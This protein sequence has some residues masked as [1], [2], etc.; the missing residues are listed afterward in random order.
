MEM[1]KWMRQNGCPWNELACSNAARGGHLEV[2]QWL[3][4][5]GC[6]WN[7]D[8]CYYAALGGGHLEVL[9]WLRPMDILG[10]NMLKS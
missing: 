8:A 2:L 5:N 7:Q 4:Q 1:L 9:Q 6:P 10:V 3:K